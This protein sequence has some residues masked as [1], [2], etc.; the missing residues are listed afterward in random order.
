MN[1]DGLKEYT[2][3]AEQKF[4]DA[5]I[6]L[7]NPSDTRWFTD[8]MKIAYP[9]KARRSILHT[10]ALLSRIEHEKNETV[11]RQSARC[12]VIACQACGY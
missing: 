5:G 8:Q 12:R 9:K 4:A 6:D 7:L 3:M 2:Q 11:G 10:Y 1:L